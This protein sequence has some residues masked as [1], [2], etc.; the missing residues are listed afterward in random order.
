MAKIVY[1]YILINVIKH[2]S[3]IHSFNRIVCI[4]CNSTPL[5]KNTKTNKSNLNK[6][7]LTKL[8]TIKINER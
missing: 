4:K 1:F 6:L 2:V 7:L 3:D 8:T 5:F